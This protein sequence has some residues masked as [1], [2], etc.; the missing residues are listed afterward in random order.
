MARTEQLSIYL[1]K[2]TVNQP[3]N[4]LRAN[5][6]FTSV[7]LPVGSPADFELYTR[8]TPPHSPGWMRFFPQSTQQAIQG[9]L[10]ASAGAVLFVKSKNRLFA[11]C[12]GTGWHL[13]AK[14]SFVRGFGLRAALSLVKRDT[15][16]SVDVSTYENFAKHRR[17]STSKGTTIDSF[18]IE[19]QLDLLRG[20]IGECSASAVGQHIGGKDACIVWTKIQ[21]SEIPRLCKVLVSAYESKRVSKHYPI[22][23]QVAEVRDPSEVQR[24]D[25]LL[26]SEFAAN[27]NYDASVAPPEV[28]DWQNVSEF[29]LDHPNA[30][31]PSISLSFADVR[32]LFAPNP[33]TL[34]QLRSIILGTLTPNGTPGTQSWTLYDCIVS[35][36]SDPTDPSVRCILMAGDWYVVSASFV[37]Q[38]NQQLASIGQHA[39][40][41]PNA[42]QGETEG[43]YNERFKNQNPLT[44]GLLDKKNIS[45]GGGNSRIEVCDVIS[46]Q[47]CLYHVKDYHGSATLSHLF[48]QG[49]VSARLLLEQEFRQEVINKHPNL[50]GAP[51]Q[52][53]SINPNNIEVVYAIICEPTRSI[54]SGLPFFSKVRLNESVKELRR[55]GY[56]NVTVARVSR[57]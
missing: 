24:L 7:Q 33:P 4:A 41:L 10:S 3:V 38:V 28:V 17:V 54:P 35:E 56:T 57:P 29:V 42:L 55:M 49:T 31:A 13:L 40:A 14:D 5:S 22:V 46:S 9:L 26:D 48:A 44:H 8:S 6:H 36:I 34:S 18:D 30:P 39:V 11:I 50:P 37:T 12:F 27:P 32:N 21:F 2:S 1:L 16:K 23:N 20:V 43:V 51:I 25:S 19:G 53:A 47:P 15:L 52:L 45:Y